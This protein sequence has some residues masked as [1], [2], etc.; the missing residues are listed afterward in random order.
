MKLAR[1]RAPAETGTVHTLLTVHGNVTQPE[2]PS[3]VDEVARK[4][5]G[6]TFWGREST[7]NWFHIPFPAPAVSGQ[8]IVKLS[9][10]YVFFHNTSRSPVMAVHLY[11]GA[12]LLKSFDKLGVFGDHASKPDTANSFRLDKP[13]ALKHGLG[14]SVQVAFPAD[15][16]EK[17]PRWILFTSAMA[18]FR[19]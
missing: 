9:R 6:S 13:V 15:S 1:T 8:E 7:T 19:I 10:V 16:S 17:P 12:K 5:W 3:S 18:E 4:G 2:Y 14:V 11:D